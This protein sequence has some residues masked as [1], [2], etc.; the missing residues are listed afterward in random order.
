MSLDEVAPP[1]YHT[2]SPTPVP[3]ED[4]LPFLSIQSQTYDQQALP[5]QDTEQVL[6]EDDLSRYTSQ[7]RHI[8]SPELEL[9]LRKAHYLPEDD[10]DE[11]PA[12]EWQSRYG[13]GYFE[14][15]RLRQ[16]YAKRIQ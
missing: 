4:D 1:R 14:L 9:K 12:Q 16:L 2:P 8:I 5:A 11:V 7:N 6:H 13:V 3:Q 15:K 10:P